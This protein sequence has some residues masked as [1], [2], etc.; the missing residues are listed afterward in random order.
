D[1]DWIRVPMITDQDRAFIRLAIDE[2]KQSRSEPGKVSPMVGAVVVKGN[3]VIASAHRGEDEGAKDHAE[4]AALE[5]KLKDKESPAGATVYTTLEPCT[6]RPSKRPCARHLLD[7]KVARVVIGMLDPN[8]SIR[9]KGVRLLREH[10]V[11]VDLFPTEFAN[12]VEDL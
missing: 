3:Q 4:F 9:G 11:E 1:S 7:R 2:S 10:N 5:K 6:S 12:E 8:P